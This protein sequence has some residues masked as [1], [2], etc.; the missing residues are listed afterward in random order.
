MNTP[1]SATATPAPLARNAIEA[2]TAPPPAVTSQKVMTPA[3]P[4]QPLTVIVSKMP[5]EKT[6]FTG[7]LVSGGIG[8]VST[9]AAVLLTLWLTNSQKEREERRKTDDHCVEVYAKIAAVLEFAHGFVEHFKAGAAR[10]KAADAEFLA[11][12][13][14]AY[15]NIPAEVIFNQE[16]M[17]ALRRVS[18]YKL[19]SSAPMIERK[20][21]SVIQTMAVYRA[22]IEEIQRLATVERVANGVSVVSFPVDLKE[23]IRAEYGMLD[24]FV[25]TMNEIC[26]ELVHTCFESMKTLIESMATYFN[27]YQGISI[28]D[29]QGQVVEFEFNLKKKRKRSKKD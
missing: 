24:G 6:D 4:Q 17:A 8:A 27:R 5:E 26:E 16:E 19:L 29:P 23:R 14:Q 22:K 1:K 20:Y 12:H 3:T 15:T 25:I 11:L 28:T 2:S 7:D 9:L 21:R 18:N 10:A 13:I